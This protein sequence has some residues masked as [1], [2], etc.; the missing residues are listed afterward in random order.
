MQNLKK[1]ERKTLEELSINANW[2]SFL[3]FRERKLHGLQTGISSLDKVL[4]GLSGI[5]V[6]QGAPGSNKSTLAL[7]IATHNAGLGHPSLIIDR[8]NGRERFRTRMLCQA[9]R[10]S[11][12]QVLTAKQE[13]LNA[14][15]EKVYDYPIYVE[16]E[17]IGEYDAINALLQELWETHKKPMLLVVDSVQALPL[18]EADERLSIQAWMQLFDQAKLD[19]EGRLNIIV[20]SEKS[21]GMGGENYDRAKL[22]AGKGA[23]SIDY[24]AEQVLDLRQNT[25]N[26]NLICEIVK[27]RDGLSG[28]SVELQ[29]LLANPSNPQSF[30]FKLGDLNG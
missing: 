26:G 12:T 4:L 3:A 27:N 8:E 19:Y 25:E 29:K 1:L 2:K 23:N 7:Q 20:T 6:I 21:R 16:T 18:I 10:I 11:Q 13:S 9:N 14:W 15:V 22:G 5:S 28:V 24:K 17:P 30:C